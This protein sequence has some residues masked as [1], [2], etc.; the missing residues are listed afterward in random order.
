[1]ILGLI[2]LVLFAPYFLFVPGVGQRILSPSVFLGRFGAPVMESGD[3]AKS[4]A[5]FS[6]GFHKHERQFSGL[7]QVDPPVI[8]P[9][10]DTAD[11]AFVDTFLLDDAA[12]TRL[13]FVVFFIWAWE[14]V[15]VLG[16]WFFFFA[17]A[18]HFFFFFFFFFFCSRIGFCLFFP[19]RPTNIQF[20][21]ILFYL[22]IL[23]ITLF[24]HQHCSR[25]VPGAA[26]NV[27]DR[28]RNA[29]WR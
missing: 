2:S 23:I 9:P 3:L 14:L 17:P 27:R 13:G 29:G 28:D 24:Y 21:P 15:F 6:A 20:D 22:S 18:L 7:E 4:L 1:V 8:L 5:H 12:K 11:P 26:D 25:S 10:F 16:F 19:R